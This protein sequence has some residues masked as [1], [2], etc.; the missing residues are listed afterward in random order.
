MV[1]LYT[2]QV[3]SNIGLDLEIEGRHIRL[4]GVELSV[5]RDSRPTRFVWAS[6]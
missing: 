2:G 5:D 4:E 6:D 3:L 1:I